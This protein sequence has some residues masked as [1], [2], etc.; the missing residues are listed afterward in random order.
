MPCAASLLT[1]TSVAA[2]A[3]THSQCDFWIS[4]M[5]KRRG[6]EP[7]DEDALTIVVV[8][9]SRQQGQSLLHVGQEFSHTH[10]KGQR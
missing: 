2:W 3:R 7:A 5:R 9:V 8:H 10:A 4:A 6:K 1:L